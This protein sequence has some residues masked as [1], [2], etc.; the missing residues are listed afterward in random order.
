[1]SQTVKCL[2]PVSGG[3]DSQVCLELAIKE[4]GVNSVLGLFC[5]TQFEHPL[6]YEHIEKMKVMYGITIITRC[7]GDVLSQCRKNKRF[8]SDD[9]R[10]CTN[11]LK[12]R[13]T[14]NFCAWLAENQEEG[15]EVWYGMRRKESHG[16]AKRYEN[17]IDDELYPPHIILTN[18]PKYLE[19]MGVMFRL[20]ICDWHE[21]EVYNQLGDRI[22]PLYAKGF[23]RVGCFPCLA[24]G[25]GFKDIAFNLDDFG[26][27]QREKV[28]VVEN[29]LGKDIFT[30]KRGFQKDNKDQI[31][32]CFVCQI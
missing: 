22:N 18:Y 23:D 11:S 5:D 13:V 8:P 15:F 19:K 4:F 12:I 2:V 20:P 3:K 9:V 25:D 1:M 7:D 17:T 30:S 21:R 31:S 28:R 14:K 26:R 32:L 24:G 27:E 6:T 16:R 29:E 10:F